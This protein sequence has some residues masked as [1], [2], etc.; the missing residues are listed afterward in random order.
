MKEYFIVANS[1]A[2]PIVSDRSTS[3]VKSADPKEAL[4]QFKA[5]YDHPCGL[6]AVNVYG[7]ADDYHKEK[8][9]LCQWLC[10]KAKERMK[11]RGG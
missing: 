6:Y 3:Y 10:N 5:N 1:F 8:E 2:A 11:R 9:P 4:R 7:S